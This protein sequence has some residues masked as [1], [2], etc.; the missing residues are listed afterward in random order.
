MVR[1]SDEW[2]ESEE[3][4]AHLDRILAGCSE[5][6]ATFLR[7]KKIARYES[8]SID[9]RRRLFEAESLTASRSEAEAANPPTR[10]DVRRNMEELL[11]RWENGLHDFEIYYPG[12]PAK[13]RGDIENDRF[14]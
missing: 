8:S 14:A 9:K 4:K 6:C 12:G 5:E 2:L 3:F 10:E 1:F 13:L 7:Q 11:Y